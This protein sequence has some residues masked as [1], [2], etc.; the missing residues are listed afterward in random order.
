MITDI[1]SEDRLV[2][3]TFAAHLKDNLA[4]DTVYAFNDETFGPGGTLGRKDTTEAVL[5]REIP[6]GVHGAPH[7]PKLLARWLGEVGHLAQS[8]NRIDHLA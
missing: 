2:Q 5:T 8:L 7:D 3:A 6:A 1:H 4:W